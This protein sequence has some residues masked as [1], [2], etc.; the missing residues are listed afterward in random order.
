[1]TSTSGARRVQRPTNSREEDRFV[2]KIRGV[3]G[4]YPAPGPDTYKVGGNTPCVEV[5]VAG[6]LIILDAGTGIIGLGE[7]LMDQYFGRHHKGPEVG[8]PIMATILLSHTHHD[9]IHGFP[10]FKPAYLGTSVLHVFGPKMLQQDL[11]E[12]LSS[13]MVAPFFPIELDDMES[14]R[15]VQSV[16]QGDVIVLNERSKTPRVL[17][18]HRDQMVEHPQQV[19]VKIMKSFAHPKSGVFVYRIEWRG[20]SLVYATDTESYQGMDTRLTMFARGTDLLIHDAQYTHEEYVRAPS[21]KQGFGHSTVE[22]A[23]R[24]AREADAKRLLLFHHDPLHTDAMM[25][26][27]ERRARKLFPHAEVAREGATYELSSHSSA[28]MPI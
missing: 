26:Q 8:Q 1:V 20:R 7:E 10:F 27:I 23:A 12:Q 21:P 15:Y 14:L 19:Q 18:R 24:I 16:G 4:G 17:N 25:K 5:R 6:H 22:M 2:V 11:E 9:H 28:R 13:A 3:R